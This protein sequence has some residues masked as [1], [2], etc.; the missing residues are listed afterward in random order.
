MAHKEKMAIHE[1]AVEYTACNLIESG[2]TTRRP[3]V[4][5]PGVDLV[6]D[7]GKTIIVRG[8]SEEKASPITHKPGADL[9]ADY[10]II[11]TNMKYMCIRNIYV[12]SNDNVF[13][14]AVNHPVR[15]TG[16]DNWFISVK[17]YRVNAEGYEVLN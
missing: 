1:K 8:Q 15:K 5:T 4:P 12:I 13:N 2:I 3:K 9:V 6:L 17:D 11:A 16:L 7:N 10:V 14:I